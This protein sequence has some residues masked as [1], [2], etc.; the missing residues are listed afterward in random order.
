MTGAEPDAEAASGAPHSPQKRSSG[1]LAVPQAAQRRES[2]LP[3]ARQNFRVLAFSAPQ[4]GH[5][6]RVLAPFVRVADGP[7]SAV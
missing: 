5:S 3:Q 1:S 7:S 6:N 4:A 2:L